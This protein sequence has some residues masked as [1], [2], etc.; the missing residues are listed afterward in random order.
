MKFRYPALYLLLIIVFVLTALSSNAPVE[1]SADYQMPTSDIPTVTGTAV[2]AAI[3]VTMDQEQINV[4]SGP[5]TNYPPVGILLAKQ[6]APAIGKSAGGDWIQIVYPGVEGSTAWV[7]APLVNL[8]PGSVLPIVEPPSTPTPLVTNTIDPTLAS[9]FIYTSEP[10]R[11]P[12]FTP[13]PPLKIATYEPGISI[14]DRSNLPVGLIIIILF[15]LG[16]L[17]GL[18]SLVQNR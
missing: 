4:R 16:I 1:G 6:T 18:I 17:I 2:G 9:Q 5:G 3:T 8:T 11:L 14:L 12:T 13:A 10:T 7:F 15:S